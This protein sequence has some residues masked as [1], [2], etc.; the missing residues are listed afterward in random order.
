ML[1]LRLR[2]LFSI[3]SVNRKRTDVNVQGENTGFFSFFFLNTMATVFKRISQTLFQ[4]KKELWL[5]RL[6]T[7]I[8]Q[9]GVNVNTHTGSLSTIITESVTFCTSHTVLD[10]PACS[11]VE[12]LIVEKFS[13]TGRTSRPQR[14]SVGP[15]AERRCWNKTKKQNEEE[16]SRFTA[17]TGASRSSSAVTSPSAP[18]VHLLLVAAPETS[19][20]CCKHVYC[21]H[22][23]RVCGFTELSC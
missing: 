15:R 14:D 9:S 7:W 22:L 13:Q 1:C 5:H 21:Q 19:C 23:G 11:G 10:H 4:R 18:E 16:A 8:L 20:F 2:G 6:D 3:W 17:I 12:T